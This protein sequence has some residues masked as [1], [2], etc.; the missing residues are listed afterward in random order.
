[1]NYFEIPGE[2]DAALWQKSDGNS[3]VVRE[4]LN[5]WNDYLH[6]LA[7]GNTLASL[8]PADTR[9]LDELRVDALGLI[10]IAADQAL[11]PITRLYPRAEID[12]WPEQCKEAQ[13]W[14]SDTM[15][16]APLIDAICGPQRMAE[17]RELCETILSKAITYREAVGAVIGWRRAITSWVEAQSEPALL[18]SFTP[19]CPEVPDAS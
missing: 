12:T 8:V 11:E 19:R 6:W 15:A 4:G 10:N 17:K 18:I 13:A 5:G 16:S 9:S 2:P 1:M 3:G 7:A 14:L